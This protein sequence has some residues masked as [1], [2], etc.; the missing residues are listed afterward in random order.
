MKKMIAIVVLALV[1]GGERT[2][3]RTVS[4]GADGKASGLELEKA[5]Q[6]AASGDTILV[7]PGVYESGVIYI[8]NKTLVV[9]SVAGPEKTVLDGMK[10]RLVAWIRITGEST[11]L[12]G[13]TIRNGYDAQFGGGIRIADRSNPTIR[14]N[15]F[16]GCQSPWGGGIYVGPH[17]KPVIEGNLFRS[18]LATAAGGAIYTQYA[19]PII[20]GNTFIG[21]HSDQPGSAIGLYEA[22][23][24]IE[25]N[26]FVNQ[27]GATAIYLRGGKCTAAMSCNGYFG[28]QGSDVTA[29]EGA[30]QPAEKERV[31]GDPLFKDPATGALSPTSPYRNAGACGAIGR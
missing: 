10:G 23:P 1:T 6:A 18:N 29:G 5:V 4:I 25:R 13:F 24:T 31:T 14:N 11:V 9:K 2:D 17:C 8:T 16:E 7:H 15:I 3:A 22:S 27:R 12:E 30:A 21:N 28:N 26:L 19:Q 20:R